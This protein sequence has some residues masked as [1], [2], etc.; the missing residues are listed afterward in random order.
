[1]AKKR[2][3]VEPPALDDGYYW[4][5][6]FVNLDGGGHVGEWKLARIV[7][8]RV[9]RVGSA[10]VIDRGCPYLR[11][12]LWVR[13]EPPATDMGDTTAICHATAR[14]PANR[15]GQVEHDGGGGPGERV[16]I[17]AQG[18]VDAFLETHD[19][20]G[21]HYRSRPDQKEELIAQ[22]ARLIERVRG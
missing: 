20:V 12:A 11:D 14:R 15:A 2:R 4:Y 16:R 13:A 18:I 21:A 9:Q 6:N 17:V 22:I 3:A 10:A 5:R 19:S 1:M 7:R 8:G